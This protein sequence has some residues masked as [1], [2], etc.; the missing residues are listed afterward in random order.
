MTKTTDRGVKPPITLSAHD[1]EALSQLARAAAAT[2]PDAASELTNELD[3]AHI[4]AKG[5]HPVGIVCMGCEVAY[6]DDTTGRVQTVT[7]V[8]PSEADI[9]KGRASVLTPVGTALIGLAVGKS[10]NWKT[11]TGEIK[12][13]TVL[14]V[15]DPRPLEPPGADS[16]A[17]VPQPA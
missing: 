5:R 17:A 8:Y 16:R 9:A 3:R 10:I 1:Y 12:R 14:Q 2:M 6:R 13:L 4:L 15:H 11:R 7:L